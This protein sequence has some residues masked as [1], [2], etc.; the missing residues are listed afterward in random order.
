MYVGLDFI[1]KVYYFEGSIPLHYLTDSNNV[2]YPIEGL[3][4]EKEC[5]SKLR[6]SRK[7][8]AFTRY[9]ESDIFNDPKD[10]QLKC[11]EFNSDPRSVK[12]RN[13]YNDIIKKEKD[14]GEKA[15]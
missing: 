9:R 8:I 5:L 10:A 14:Y 7:N 12:L 3:I 15:R 13:L 2:V 4:Y 1:A 11:D 6:S